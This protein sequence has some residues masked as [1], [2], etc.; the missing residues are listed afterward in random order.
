MSKSGAAQ[1]ICVVLLLAFIGFSFFGETDTE[2]TA[3]EIAAAVTENVSTE[4]LVSFDEER[5]SGQFGI[6][7]EDFASFVY[8]GSED[9]MDVREILVLKCKEETDSEKAAEL[10]E[11]KAEEKYSTYKD[12]DPV[13]SSLLEKRA[14]QVKRGAI[15]YIVDENAAAGLEAFLRCVED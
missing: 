7:A 14:M 4:G 10:I 13:A 1:L 11:K 8:Y 3:D 12:Y 15:I 2:K 5:L 6:S 9:I